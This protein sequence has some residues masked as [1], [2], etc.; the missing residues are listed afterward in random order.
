MHSSKAKH[1]YITMLAEVLHCYTARVQSARATTLETEPD[2]VQ[3]GAGGGG[4]GGGAWG[5]QC[6]VLFGNRVPALIAGT[7]ITVT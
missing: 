6:H 4:G 1:C 2:E 3:L 5:G 7:I